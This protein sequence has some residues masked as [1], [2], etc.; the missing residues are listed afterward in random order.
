MNI[1]HHGWTLFSKAMERTE[2][3]SWPHESSA[4]LTH[5]VF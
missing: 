1:L 3:F 5:V 2:F 4:V